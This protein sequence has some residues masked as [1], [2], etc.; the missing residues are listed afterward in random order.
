MGILYLSAKFEP[1]RFTNNGDLLLDRNHWKQRRTNTHTE[2]D[3]HTHR[4]NLILSPSL[5]LDSSRFGGGE[6]KQE[7]ERERKRE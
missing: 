4:L 1:G 3:R 5:I 2:T 7:I 6:R